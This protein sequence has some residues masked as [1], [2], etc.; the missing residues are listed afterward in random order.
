MLSE[1][2][3]NG[4]NTTIVVKSLAHVIGFAVAVLDSF[5][6]ALK[7]SSPAGCTGTFLLLRNS[8]G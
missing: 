5:I 7:I 2:N 6:V 4:K 8:C 1:A 3:E